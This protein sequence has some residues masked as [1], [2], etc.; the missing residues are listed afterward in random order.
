MLE[1]EIP[2]G[3]AQHP[4]SQA[5]LDATW[6]EP[7]AVLDDDFEF[8][9]SLRRLWGS[10]GNRDYGEAEVVA[11]CR[12][13][14][15]TAIMNDGRGRAT[16]RRNGVASVCTGALLAAVAAEH[17]ITPDAAWSLHQELESGFNT[18]M[19]L[20]TGEEYRPAFDRTV[21][22]IRRWVRDNTDLVWPATL[23]MSPPIDD[24]LKRAVGLAAASQNR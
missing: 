17:F 1:S 15:W 9:V 4:K 24:L 22:G 18:P 21:A 2:R 10:T 20:P 6:L 5:I 12:R 13:Y 19:I 11:L 7:A 14:G 16:A 23:A 3:I 8:I